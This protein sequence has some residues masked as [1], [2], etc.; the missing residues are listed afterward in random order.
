MLMDYVGNKFGQSMKVLM[1]V[2]RM[3]VTEVDEKLIPNF[4]TEEDK[5]KHVDELE[6][7]G[8]ELHE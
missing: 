3:I 2:G 8:V 6:Y 1:L 4:E 5:R 7:W